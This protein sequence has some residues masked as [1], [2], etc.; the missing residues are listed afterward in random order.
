MLILNVKAPKRTKADGENYE[1]VVLEFPDGSEGV[2]HFF[3]RVGDRI[4]CGLEMPEAV[5]IRRSSII[6]QI[7]PEK[8]SAFVDGLSACVEAIQPA[9]RELNMVA[10]GERSQ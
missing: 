9:A 2:I 5:G 6:D 4:K 1:R 8:L 7:P 10:I 3:E